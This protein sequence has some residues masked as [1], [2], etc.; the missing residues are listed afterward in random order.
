VIFMYS[1][2]SSLALGPTQPPVQ[3]VP[4]FFPGSKAVSRDVDH[5]SPLSTEVEVRVTI[6]LLPLY[7]FTSW[8]GT[9]PSY[10]F[11]LQKY[12]Y[13]SH[14]HFTCISK[15]KKLQKMESSG[16]NITK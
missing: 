10:Y 13:H 16:D 3:L 15:G 4:G 8:T 12:M 7:T 9:A 5:S 14:N 6:T 11:A 2:S 1:Q